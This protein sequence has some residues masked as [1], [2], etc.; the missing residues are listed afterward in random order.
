MKRALLILTLAAFGPLAMGADCGSPSPPDPEACELQCEFGLKQ[1]SAGV[2]F[3]ECRPSAACIEIAAEPHRDPAT[4]ACHAFP[5]VCD[6]P[7]G[8]APCG[9][10][11][12]EECGPAP[13][14][15][16][17]LC[18]DGSTGGPACERELADGS[19]GWIFREC[20]KV[21]CGGFAGVACP[22]GFACV[23]DPSDSCDPAAGGADCG[24]MCVPAAGESCGPNTCET[25]EV[26]CNA[27]CGICTPPDGA[28]IQ[29]ACEPLE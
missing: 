12:L 24:G 15:P 1:D 9:A 10:C 3:C 20:P 18:A 2:E 8:W 16:S 28:C 23:D 11:T 22:S 13:G 26:C 19:C 25:G 29:V 5:S 17:A 4:G 7:E 27:S 21:F 6:I 14:A